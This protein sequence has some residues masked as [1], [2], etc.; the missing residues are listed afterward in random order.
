MDEHT[1]YWVWLQ[2]ALGA[3][4]R[5]DDLLGAFETAKALYESSEN[6][7]RLSGVLTARQLQKLASTPLSAAEEILR[8]CGS[9]RQDVVTPQDA[10]YP[11][12]LR[13]LSDL[14]LALYV[15]GDLYCLDDALA[16]AMV[17]SR[18]ASIYSLGVART[19]SGEAA[20]A[21]ITPGFCR[22]IN[23]ERLR[24]TCTAS[25]ND[26]TPANAAAVTSP[27]L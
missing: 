27:M 6:D 18:G 23:S 22:C 16:I 11:A 4:A 10:L 19:L 25:S 1:V 8:R 5:V 12:A 15:R 20:T 3:A 21:S 7:R 9:A 24:T 26:H 17:G 14:P 2:C 13:S